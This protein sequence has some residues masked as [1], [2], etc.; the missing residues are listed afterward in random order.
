MSYIKYHERLIKK[1]NLIIT[2]NT[3]KVFL[4]GAHIFSQYLIEFGLNVNKIECILDNDAEKQGKRLYGSK[5]LVKAPKILKDVD[6]P[7]I[8]LKAG[9]YN[10]EIKNDILKN[11][12]PNAKFI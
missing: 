3:S 9:T 7:L 1:L 2:R 4:F 11:I 12:N 8:I 6:K 10:N 5:L